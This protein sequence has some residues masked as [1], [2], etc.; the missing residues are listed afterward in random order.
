MFGLLANKWLD[1]GQGLGA[2]GVPPLAL[3]GMGG[4]FSPKRVL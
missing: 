4:V 2:Y 3:T 1:A